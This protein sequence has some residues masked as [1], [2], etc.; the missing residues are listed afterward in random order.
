M[1]KTE[2]YEIL[3]NDKSESERAPHFA[4]AAQ[5]A[6]GS[7]KQSPPAE[8]LLV[9]FELVAEMERWTP[10][11]EGDW[12]VLVP[13]EFALLDPME[14]LPGTPEPTMLRSDKELP[15]REPSLSN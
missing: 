8:A 5:E 11:W 4:P 9:G 3:N 7:R 13:P 6:M 2:I 15:D 10:L 14:T 1:K 12:F